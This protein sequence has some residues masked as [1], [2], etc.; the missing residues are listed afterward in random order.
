MVFKIIVRKLYKALSGIK[1][2]AEDDKKIKTKKKTSLEN[3]SSLNDG[4][5]QKIDKSV[6]ESLNNSQVITKNNDIEKSVTN[7]INI[8]KQEY[9]K[10]ISDG[11]KEVYN[12]WDYVNFR[13]NTQAY[14]L[15][16]VIGY[17]W[18]SMDEIRRRIMELFHVNFINERS[19]YPYIKTMVDMGLLET[20]DAGGKRNWRKR[21]LFFEIKKKKDD[22]SKVTVKSPT[23]EKVKKK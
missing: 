20:S 16:K 14:Y 22:E 3:S 21:P 15:E 4:N 10:D 6:G 13:D 8:A 18:I 5:Y 1:D 9:N 12:L 11:K 7:E 2:W 23:D 17:D 19:L